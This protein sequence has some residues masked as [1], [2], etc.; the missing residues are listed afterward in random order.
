MVPTMN[1]VFAPTK[2]VKRAGNTVTAKMPPDTPEQSRYY[3]AAD[4]NDRAEFLSHPKVPSEAIFVCSRASAGCQGTL[5]ELSGR[6]DSRLEV[7]R[8]M[9]QGREAR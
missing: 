5:P 3:I 7:L 1:K 2:V 8:Q 6:A 4:I 9:R